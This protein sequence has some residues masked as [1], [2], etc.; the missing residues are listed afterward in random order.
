[1]SIPTC[2]NVRENAWAHCGERLRTE[3][4]ARDSNTRASGDIWH[5]SIDDLFEP[6]NEGMQAVGPGPFVITLRTSNAPMG[7][8][9]QGLLR[10]E[11]L[12]VY[13]LTHTEA[14]RTQYLLRLGII[15]T[16]LEADTILE[17]VREHYPRASKDAAG[18]NDKAAVTR[19]VGAAK[20]PTPAGPQTAPA[21][22][23]GPMRTPRSASAPSRPARESIRDF[24]VNIDEILPELAETYAPTREPTPAIAAKPEPHRDSASASTGARPRAPD[25]ATMNPPTPPRARPTVAPRTVVETDDVDPNAVTDQVEALMLPAEGQAHRSAATADGPAAAQ[26]LHAEP[27]I[28]G[29]IHE[30]AHRVPAETPR[31]PAQDTTLDEFDHSAEPLERLVARIGGLVEAT[32]PHHAKRKTEAPRTVPDAAAAERTT[33]NAPSLDS[34]Q[35]VRALTPI[36]LADHESSHWFAIQ[37]SL[38]EERVNAEEVPN[39]DIFTEYRLYSVTG[40]H[41]D[42]IVHALRVGFFTSKIA[43]E[44]VAGYLAAYFHEPTIKRISIAER[45]RFAEQCVEARKDVGATGVHAVIALTG[46]APL[47]VRNA[48]TLASDSG[49]RPALEASSLWSRLIAPRNR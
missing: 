47:P 27:A 15:G 1:M 23:R 40:L 29:A 2:G 7:L 18:A 17:S 6:T 36:E 34:T 37:L 19:A 35:T 28:D 16:D 38:G 48:E 20:P 22:A 12:H 30:P 42:R 5:L 33:K 13:E 39:L 3:G 9:P 49:K 24:C 32:K 44:A 31:A 45:E 4:V 26:S 21:T 25:R 8:P 43:A 46:P 41:D 11:Q 10:F 14:S